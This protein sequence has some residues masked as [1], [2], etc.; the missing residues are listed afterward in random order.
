M[1]RG[2]ASLTVLLTVVTCGFYFGVKFPSRVELPSVESSASTIT[3]IVSWLFPG[4]VQ[5]TGLSHQPLPGCPPLPLL[6]R[7]DHVFNDVLVVSAPWRTEKW[8]RLSQQLARRNI[9]HSIVH[10]YWGTSLGFSTLFKHLRRQK[11]GEGRRLNAGEVAL[12]ATWLEILSY[13]DRSPYENVLILD[14]DALLLTE[15]QFDLEFDRQM[16][17]IP[18]DWKVLYLG[19]SITDWISDAFLLNVSEFNNLKRTHN[20]PLLL[21][22]AWGQFAIALHRT[23]AADALSKQLADPF[24]R[25]FDDEGLPY[26]CSKHA[27]KCMSFWPFLILPDLRSSA[28]RVAKNGSLET[29]GKPWNFN[30]SSVDL[31]DVD[32]SIPSPLPVLRVNK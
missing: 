16:R 30:Y 27:G 17:L 25:P 13:L 9:T 2:L 20:Q 24:T 21:R 4:D 31:S 8:L 11:K 22:K 3:P 5:F 1:Q 15:E 7:F 29:L 18:P 10:A 14:D 19:M 12:T 26:A 6:C 28:L 32:T 23:A